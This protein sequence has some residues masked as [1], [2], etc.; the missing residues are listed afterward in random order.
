VSD[1]IDKLF[2]SRYPDVAAELAAIRAEATDLYGRQ[3]ALRTALRPRPIRSIL[4]KRTAARTEPPEPEELVQT[5]REQLKHVEARLQEIEAARQNAELFR[6]AAAQDLR[7]ALGD[8]TLNAIVL[9][10]EGY[11][12][13]LPVECWRASAGWDAVVRGRVSWWIQGSGGPIPIK[14]QAFVPCAEFDRWHVGNTTIGG[15]RRL[16]QWL[17]VQMRAAPSAPRSKVVMKEVAKAA[18]FTFSEE[19]FGRCWSAAIDEASAPA[20]SRGGRRK[21]PQ[22]SRQEIT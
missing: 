4:D 1:A 8:G 17:V 11:S 15:E 13:P 12:F 5:R 22:G 20:W 14:G 2:A 16:T 6:P 9:T 7:K 19:G 10:H 3:D 21:A 18:G